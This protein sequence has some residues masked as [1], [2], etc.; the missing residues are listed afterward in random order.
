MFKNV[1]NKTGIIIFGAVVAIFVALPIFA[2]SG[3]HAD[4]YV[5]AKANGT[6]N[7]SKEHPYETISQAI[8]KAKGNTEIHV[9]NGEYKENIT[10]KKDVKILGEDKKKTIIK[11]KKDK[12]ATVTMKD[13]SEINDFTIKNGEVGILVESHDSAKIINC[14]VKNNDQDGI[15]I[16]GSD[17]K[18]SHQVIISKTEVKENNWSGIFSNG[19]RRVVVTESDILNNKK[20][21]IDLA[22]G[23][24]AWIAGNS[25]NENKGS[26]LKLT[27][28]A[29]DIWTKNNSVR[30]NSREG[31][32]VSF[33]GG[34]GR[35]DVSKSK[36]VGNGFY[37]IAK[38]QRASFGNSVGSWNKYLTIDG[39]NEFWDNGKGSISNIFHII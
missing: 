23:A 4:L 9:S 7:G 27:V 17:I 37:G 12:W 1:N 26:G 36:F 28:D 11:A 13:G 8:H 30:R 2:F 34:S 25:I 6:E 31:M 14:I 24:S 22:R 10:I 33:F 39:K 29:S 18:K 21:G 32:E 3:R 5:N 38:I 35:V 15:F 20:D 16:E 19:P